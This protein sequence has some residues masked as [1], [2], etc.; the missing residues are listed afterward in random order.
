MLD[1]VVLEL[2]DN[3]MD[4]LVDGLIDDQKGIRNIDAVFSATPVLMSQVLEQQRLYVACDLQFL[5]ERQYQ[6][7]HSVKMVALHLGRCHLFLQNS[8]DFELKRGDDVGAYSFC[9]LLEYLSD[10]Q[11]VAKNIYNHAHERIELFLV[12]N[13]VQ[14][15]LNNKRITLQICPI[16]SLTP[17]VFLLRLSMNFS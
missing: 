1:L 17:T 15:S 14:Q 10:F 11:V 12:L 16:A 2:F 3:R 13:S 4:A 8:Y 9:H 6:R 5:L 7:Q